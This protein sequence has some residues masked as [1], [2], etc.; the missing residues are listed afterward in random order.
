MNTPEV[1]GLMHASEVIQANPGK[2]NKGD[3]FSEIFSDG[4]RTI[5][6]FADFF[7]WKIEQIAARRG[8]GAGGQ[9]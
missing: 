7:Q 4:E 8:E 9:D 2:G 6:T 1:T 5:S 3:K